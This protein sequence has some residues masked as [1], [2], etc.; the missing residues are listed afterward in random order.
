MIKNVINTDPEII[1]KLLI[2]NGAILVLIKQGVE[3]F[4]FD[5]GHSTLVELCHVHELTVVEVATV[6]I[7]CSLECSERKEKILVT[8]PN[9]QCISMVQ[10]SNK[11]IC[12]APT[13]FV[14]VVQ[15]EHSE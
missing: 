9:L 11:N 14:F 2:I 10:G 7:V 1:E 3:L 4:Q 5:L 15:A 13:K 6:I 8:G 12:V